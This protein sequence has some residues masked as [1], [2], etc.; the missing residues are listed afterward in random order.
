MIYILIIT[1]GVLIT[2]I[3][4]LGFAQKKSQAVHERKVEV[5]QQTIL[6]LLSN[7]DIQTGKIKLSEELQE[8]IQV[9]NRTISDAVLSAVTEIIE[10]ASQNNLLNKL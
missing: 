3:L 6:H 1:V 5:L 2:I 8:K 7:Q 4:F 10:T 9:A